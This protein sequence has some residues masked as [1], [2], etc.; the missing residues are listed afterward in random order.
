MS[1][2]LES[3]DEEFV[4]PKCGSTH[5]GSSEIDN[6]KGMTRHCNDQYGV[7]C[8]YTWH[9]SDDYKYRKLIKIYKKKEAE[10]E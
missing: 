8:S 6:P 5:F 4:C 1:W 9:E 10:Y 2:V 3:E 7:A